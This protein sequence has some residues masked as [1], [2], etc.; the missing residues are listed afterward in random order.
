MEKNKIKF[1]I[2]IIIIL[3][4]LLAT[5]YKINKNREE[6]LYDVLYGEIEFFAKSCYLNK[7]CEGTITLQTLYDKNYLEIKYDPV[8]K[9]ILD[10]DIEIEYINEEINIKL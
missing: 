4:I 5:V 9:E 10:S 3:F 6:K 8:T 2:P 7:E 1:Y